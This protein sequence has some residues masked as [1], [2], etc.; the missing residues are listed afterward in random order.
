MYL[1]HVYYSQKGV[2]TMNV[3]S[4]LPKCLSNGISKYLY[5]SSIKDNPYFFFLESNII[6]EICSAMILESFVASDII[7][8]EGAVPSSVS[9]LLSGRLLI[10]EVGDMRQTGTIE[11][12]SMVQDLEFF[13]G[14]RMSSTLVAG[15]HTEMLTLHRKDYDRIFLHFP[16]H[17][18]RMIRVSKKKF[19]RESGAQPEEKNS[20]LRVCPRSTI[21]K[22]F[23]NLKFRD[24]R[25]SF[26]LPGIRNKNRLFWQRIPT[27]SKLYQIW[28]S[29]VLIVIFVEAA[30]IIFRACFM[31]SIQNWSFPY[32]VKS[33]IGE[34]L[35]DII[36]MADIYLHLF[37]FGFF[38]R[39]S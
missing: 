32:F 17:K 27:S 7:I 31:Q 1:T 16:H 20:N 18:D 9:L 6:M 2:E 12:S 14:E 13:L 29:I 8:V 26:D 33:F 25:G 5:Y 24:G 35:M 23:N 38:Q 34:W 30:A 21:A 3:I 36:L 39:R 4:E 22:S 28:E 10:L 19:K 37:M 11:P 15:D